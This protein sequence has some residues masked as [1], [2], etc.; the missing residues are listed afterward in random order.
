MRTRRLQDVG[1]PRATD[2][3]ASILAGATASFLPRREVEAAILSAR[4]GTLRTWAA[5]AEKRF[6]EVEGGAYVLDILESVWERIKVSQK[7]ERVN[8]AARERASRR[9]AHA[10]EFETDEE[11]ERA[12]DRLLSGEPITSWKE[13]LEEFPAEIEPEIFEA[14]PRDVEWALG[15]NAP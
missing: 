2:R 15:D 4:S 9:M 14:A 5:M 1:L 6:D 3:C 12:K 11:A 13:A 7:L 8:R 10:L